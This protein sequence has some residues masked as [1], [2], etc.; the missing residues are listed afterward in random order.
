MQ[1]FFRCASFDPLILQKEPVDLILELRTHPDWTVTAERGADY[2]DCVGILQSPQ[3]HLISALSRMD[4][5]QRRA[6]Q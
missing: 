5:S 6:M 1:P 3:S 2:F 4:Q